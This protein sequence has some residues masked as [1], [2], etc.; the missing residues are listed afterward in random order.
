MNRRPG[1]PPY[2]CCWCGRWRCH[3]PLAACGLCRRWY[4]RRARGMPR[5]DRRCGC[6]RN[7][8]EEGRM[9][10]PTLCRTCWRDTINRGGRC[11]ACLDRDAKEARRQKEGSDNGPSCRKGV[12]VLRPDV[13]A[14]A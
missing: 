8:P 6:D 13:P 7:I 2:R 1:E 14:E 10:R 5:E 4:E 12:S 3:E 9:D 11:K